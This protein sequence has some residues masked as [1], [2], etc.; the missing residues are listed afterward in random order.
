MANLVTITA[1]KLT[2]SNVEI[3][4]FSEGEAPG[5]PLCR[6]PR[7][8]RP[9]KGASNAKGRGGEARPVFSS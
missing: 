7:L 8:M 6:G 4:K 5:P 1:L 3:Q 2:Y 9:G